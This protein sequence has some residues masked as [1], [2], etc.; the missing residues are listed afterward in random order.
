MS[1]QFAL[2]EGE[3]VG[4]VEGDRRMPAPHVLGQECRDFFENLLRG[5]AFGA[6]LLRRDSVHRACPFGYLDAGIGE[7][8]AFRHPFLRHGDER[9][10]HEAVPFRI[11]SRRLRVEADHRRGGPHCVL[12]V[13]GFMVSAGA[14]AFPRLH[15]RLAVCRQLQRRFAGS[16]GS[17]WST[18]ARSFAGGL[19]AAPRAGA[20]QGNTRPGRTADSL[21]RRGRLE[22]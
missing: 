10:S 22:T 3:I 18:A 8:V 4:R 1:V 7:P 19:P 17:A 6:R 20:L 12:F 5:P 13:H 21:R 15:A 2:Q 14:D 16:L 9:A 11:Y